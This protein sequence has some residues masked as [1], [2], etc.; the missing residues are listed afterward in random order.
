MEEQSQ[1][2]AMWHAPES[3]FAYAGPGSVTLHTPAST[4][5]SFAGISSQHKAPEKCGQQQADRCD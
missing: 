1:K 2:R 5:S 3:R 4:L